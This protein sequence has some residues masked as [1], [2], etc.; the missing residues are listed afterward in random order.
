MKLYAAKQE[1]E[2]GAKRSINGK[3]QRMKQGYRALNTPPAGYKYEHL[4]V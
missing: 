4:T 1:R 3:N 2:N